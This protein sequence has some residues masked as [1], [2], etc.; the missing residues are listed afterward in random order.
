M[1][2][3]RTTLRSRSGRKL[4]AVREADG[5]FVDIQSYQK[6]HGEDVRRHSAAELVEKRKKATK[7]RATKS[8]SAKKKSATKKSATKKSAMKSAM[9]KKPVMRKS[10]KKKTAKKK[11]TRRSKA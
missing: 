10:A 8:K 2:K 3:K 9:K 4:Y 5:K 11:T 6:A 1:V 7:K